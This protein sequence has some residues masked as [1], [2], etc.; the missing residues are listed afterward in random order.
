MAI[1][2]RLFKLIKRKVGKVSKSSV[3]E[4]P[5]SED[6]FEEITQE[7]NHPELL[8]GLDKIQKSAILSENPR[9]LVL[10]GA[11]AGKTK[12]LLYRILH[13]L[14]NS[15]VNSGDILAM[16]FT[17][18]ARIEMLDKLIAYFEPEYMNVLKSKMD[19]LE[20]NT[21]RRELLERHNEIKSITIKTIH[22]LCFSILKTDGAKVFNTNLEVVGDEDKDNQL[23]KSKI[24]QQKIIESVIFDICNEDQ[25]FVEQVKKFIYDYLVDYAKLTGIKE[26]NIKG[27]YLTLDGKE[28]RSKSERDI[29]N[30]LVQNKIRYFYEEEATWVTKDD[31]TKR[32]R[33]D[34]Y[35][36]DYDIYIEHW[37]L[38]SPNDK[39]PKIFKDTFDKDKYLKERAWKL[40]QFRE[41]KKILIESSEKQMQGKLSDYYNYLHSELRRNTKGAI[42]FTT[43]IDFIQEFKHLRE[44]LNLLITS[45]MKIINLAKSNR[46][47]RKT[48]QENL[49]G[50]K[51]EEV[52]EFYEILLKVCQEYE[53]FLIR[54]S[55][56]DYND[57]IYKVIELFEKYPKVLSKYQ[58][59]FKHILVDEYQ[60]VSAAQVELIKLL[61]TKDN[62]LFAVG[63]DWQSI[64][65][66]RGSEIEFIVKFNKEFENS[67]IIILPFNYRSGKNI[68]EASNIVI[69]KNPQQVKKQIKAFDER[70][71]KKIFQYN[72]LNE[73]D[74]AQFIMDM[75]NKLYAEGVKFQDILLLYR[76]SR[77]LYLYKEFFKKHNFKINTKTIHSSKGLEAEIVFLIGL[78]C[79]GFPYVWEDSR[80]IQV[81]KKTDLLKKE[82]EERRVFYVAIT[83]AKESL[84]LMSEKN[85]ESEYCGDIPKEFK[86]IKDS[87]KE[88]TPEM[89]GPILNEILSMIKEGKT[90]E[91]IVDIREQ[92]QPVIESCIAKLIYFGLIDIND[93]V[94]NKTYAVIKSKIPKDEGRPRLAP[95][96]KELP[97]KITY[98][99]IRYVIADLKKGNS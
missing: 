62:N 69:M 48:I 72:A 87:N 73:I 22:A 49:Q 6:N 81:I 99:Q 20:L 19:P 66:F 90:V 16:T 94:D 17:S 24:T 31:K 68:V 56:I 11:G 76:R 97:L 9:T 29:A 50:E 63:D 79:E 93:F 28:V 39:V 78:T 60:D 1:W 12:T 8:N 65:G 82:E 41:H 83:R 18:D 88:F 77:H 32:Y 53:E 10:A 54:K 52:L 44:G 59:K 67:K 64:Y 37:W 58:K 84:F 86:I 91:E 13:L 25:D 89:L 57:M 34:F 7:L 45:L 26:S 47:S 40:G 61:L 35:L 70:S 2:D 23:Y 27:K 55:L 15:N 4:E 71:D 33:P 96:K 14:K 75:T 36:P 46:V 95:I 5:T 21:L 98:G 30:F 92:E 74:S 51:H 43:S 80:I 85:N 38:S 3:D 42:K